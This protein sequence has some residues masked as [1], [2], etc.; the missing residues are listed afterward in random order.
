MNPML[1]NQQ[2]KL[3]KVSLNTDTYQINYVL[4][5]WKYDQ[6]LFGAHLNAYSA[7]QDDNTR[8]RKIGYNLF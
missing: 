6:R 5:G 1:M 2:Y 8:M 7:Y 3:N 4:I